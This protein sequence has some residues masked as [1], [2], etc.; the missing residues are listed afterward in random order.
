VFP[1]LVA[2]MIVLSDPSGQPIMLATSSGNTYLYIDDGTHNPVALSGS[3]TTAL[4]FSYDPYGGATTTNSDSA[5]LYQNPYTYR[6]GTR[7]PA[8][9]EIKFGQRFDNPTTGNWT[10]QDTLNAPLDPTNANRY[11]YAADNPI[12]LTDPTGGLS[13]TCYGGLFWAG[14][15]AFGLGVALGSAIATSGLDLPAAVAIGRASFSL[16]GGGITVA[17]QC[18]R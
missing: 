14:V 17:R 8:T 10:Q 13:W 9:G 6:D 7:D 1:L 3:N 5:A 12:N 11:Q 4:A 2:S 15:G 16:M 18:R